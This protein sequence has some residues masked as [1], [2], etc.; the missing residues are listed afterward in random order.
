LEVCFPS[1]SFPL[2]LVV[3]LLRISG[4]GII[5]ALTWLDVMQLVTEGDASSFKEIPFAA[6]Q[7]SNAHHQEK[8]PKYGQVLHVGFRI[9]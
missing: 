7:T 8:Q 1:F 3:V 4:S 5:E 6:V 9:R 2:V